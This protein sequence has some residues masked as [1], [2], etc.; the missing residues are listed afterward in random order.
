[1]LKVLFLLLHKKKKFYNIYKVKFKVQLNLDQ[2]NQLVPLIHKIGYFCN[3]NSIKKKE[4][5]K[6]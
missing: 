2:L 4:S 6:I 3:K 5:F 1:M